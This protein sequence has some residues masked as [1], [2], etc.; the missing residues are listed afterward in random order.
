MA[1][2]DNSHLVRIKRSLEEI[3]GGEEARNFEKLFPLSKSASID[4]KFQWAKEVC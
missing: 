4:K 3:V 1:K 2:N